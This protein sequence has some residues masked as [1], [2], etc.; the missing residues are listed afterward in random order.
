MELDVDDAERLSEKAQ[1]ALYQII[2]EALHHAIQRGPPTKVAIEVE[3]RA[4]RRVEAR[5]PRRRARRAA[6]DELR[7][8]RAAGADAERERHD[9][10]GGDAAPSS[11][12]SCR[13]YVATR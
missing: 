6:A 7:R 9:R 2:R 12:S 4:D 10:A 3:I 13:P 5:D 1:V 11:A 8:H